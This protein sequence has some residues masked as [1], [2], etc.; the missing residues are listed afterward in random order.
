MKLPRVLFADIATTTGITVDAVLDPRPMIFSFSCGRD[1]GYLG[2]AFAI[3]ERKLLEIIT[4]YRPEVLAYE[5]PVEQKRG[6]EALN[7]LVTAQKLLGLVA[8]TQL[9]GFK[10][11]LRL[12]PCN[13]QE[14]RRHFTGSGWSD[15]GIVW[16]RCKQLGWQCANMDESDSAAGWDFAKGKLKAQLLTSTHR[17]TT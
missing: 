16:Q 12:M 13:L 3:Y 11:D 7:S 14:V 4:Q 5:A 1:D 8:I 10:L 9:I 17:T 15:K 2:K 6:A